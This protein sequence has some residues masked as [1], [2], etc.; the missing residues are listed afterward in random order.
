MD[1]VMT[2]VLIDLLIIVLLVIGYLLLTKKSLF[3]QRVRFSK[4]NTEYIIQ[5][6]AQKLRQIY[7]HEIASEGV[8]Y[9]KHQKSDDTR[10]DRAYVLDNKKMT[11]QARESLGKYGEDPAW[12]KYYLNKSENNGHFDNHKQALIQFIN[13]YEGY[14]GFWYIHFNGGS[15]HWQHLDR[16]AKDPHTKISQ[17]LRDTYTAYEMLHMHLI[18]R[19]CDWQN[20]SHTNQ[21]IVDYLTITEGH[22]YTLIKVVNNDPVAMQVYENKESASVAGIALPFDELFRSAQKY[23]HD[24][25]LKSHQKTKEKIKKVGNLGVIEG[26]KPDEL[27]LKDEARNQTTKVAKDQPEKQGKENKSKPQKSNS[28]YK[29]NSK[30]DK[31]TKAESK[32]KKA[33]SE[34]ASETEKEKSIV[35]SKNGSEVKS[36]KE[37]DKHDK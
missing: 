15:Y 2:T 3:R 8:A 13:K 17:H 34:K 10:Q 6:V 28:S 30:F 26:K 32:T 31:Q 9:E 1:R 22:G 18:N 36:N 35:S 4:K 37:G 7:L 25:W 16:A 33:D 21:K 24:L 29:M 14:D 11:Q 23:T 19:D 27:K 5:T 20:V 12:L